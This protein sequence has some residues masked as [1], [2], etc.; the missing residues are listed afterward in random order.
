MKWDQFILA[1]NLI[2]NTYQQ[3]YPGTQKVF[4]KSSEKSNFVFLFGNLSLFLFV[5]ATLL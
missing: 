4:C 1:I 5:K 3:K 2:Q